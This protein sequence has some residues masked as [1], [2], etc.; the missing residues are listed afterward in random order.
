MNI[1]ETDHTYV[2][3]TYK[4][5]D[6]ALVKGKG[7]RAWDDQGR[8]YIDLGSGI[9]VNIFGY[10]DEEWKK[11]VTAQLDALPH[12]SN[13]YHTEPCGK[14]AQIL[15]ERTG[16]KKVFFANSGAEAN[17]CAVKVARKYAYDKY[18]DESHSTVI[19]LK[20]SFHGRTISML[21]ATGQ[22]HF[23]QYFGPFTP[24]FVYADA[25][26]LSSVRALSEQY[27]CCAVM[28]EMVQGEGGVMPLSYGFVKGISQ[29]CKEKDMLFIVDE[30][31]TGN[32]RT[33]RLFSY[34]NFERQPDVVTTAKGLGGGLPI[35]AC[36]IGERAEHTLSYGDHGSTFGGNPAVCAGAI[37]ILERLDDALM[38][39]VREKS[40]YIIDKLNGARGL[41]SISGM[42]FMLGIDTQRPAREIAEACLKRGVLVLTAKTR[43]R[44][45]PPLTITMEE[46]DKAV[47]VLREEIERV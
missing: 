4:R 41:K 31:Q 29:L 3:N 36:L 30:V 38:Q 47:S 44:L 37:S 43:V 2:A 26:D 45:L 8:E 16:M 34:M 14:L 6:V 13:L 33:G 15:C 22:D 10:G 35:G 46:L 1:I 11:A 23:H 27:G 5:F 17:E 39:S 28:V 40:A 18:G 21:S 25:N 7:A 20:N 32:G 19:T 42:G 24:G 12:A 9:A